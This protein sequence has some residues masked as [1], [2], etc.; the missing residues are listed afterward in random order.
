MKKDRNIKSNEIREEITPDLILD[1]YDKANV[2]DEQQ[3][4]VLLKVAEVLSEHIGEDLTS[5]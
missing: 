2:S 1:I 3:K 4:K 5:D